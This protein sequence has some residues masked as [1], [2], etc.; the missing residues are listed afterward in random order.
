VELS[1]RVP[2]R[3]I[4]QS[5]TLEIELP[6][7]LACA[8]CS[9]GGCDA[10]GRSGAV[11][12]RGRKEPVEIVQVTLPRGEITLSE[13]SDRPK[14]LRLRIPE[15]GGLSETE[16]DL[17]RG[18]LLLSIRVG[19]EPDAGVAKVRRSIVPPPAAK[20][21]P[22][23]IANVSRGRAAAVLVALVVVLAVIAW[24]IARALR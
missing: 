21:I 13:S 11:S 18:H 14:V 2:A 24:Q 7:N 17:P 1:L 15:R 23:V 16:S 6:R 5:A 10:C 19:D 8:T 9:G 4:E 22:A 3:W 12:L 20:S